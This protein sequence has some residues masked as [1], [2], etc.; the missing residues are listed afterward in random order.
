MIGALRDRTTP[1]VAAR[2]TTRRGAPVSAFER[3]ALETLDVALLLPIRRGAELAAFSC[4]GPKRSG[5]I[6]TPAEL[7]LLAA[8]ATATSGRM[9][10]I[11]AEAVAAQA[12]ATEEALR[13]Y[14]PGAI[15]QRIVAGQDLEA[16]ER[17]LSVLF[18]D[19][20]GYTGFSER[21][22]AEEIFSTVNRYTEAVSR[23]VRACGGTVVEF[24]GDGMMAVFGAPEPIPDKERCAVQ[25]ARAIAA[26][27]AALPPVRGDGGPTLSVGVGIATGLTFVGNIQSADRLIWTAI[28][29]TPNLAA[30]LQA[31]TRD[32]DAAVAIDAPTRT[33]AGDAG[34]GF[35]C[36]RD[37]AIRGRSRPEDVYAL[38]LAS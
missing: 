29:N 18:V 16:G 5:D 28:G 32:L 30:R 3:A 11:D 14:V 23:E 34:A 33:R 21:R 4:L 20:R 37:V 12:R 36:H 24:H 35:R 8:L 13:R 1:I 2:W 7:A 38:P 19:I 10:S 27:V 31:L 22:A 25:A 15:A 6:Y 17:E 9:Q 26:T